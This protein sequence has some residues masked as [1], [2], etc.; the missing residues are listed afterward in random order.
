VSDEVVT[1]TEAERRAITGPGGTNNWEAALTAVEAI[2]TARLAPIEALA[3]G[4]Q[5]SWDE[6]QA[7]AKDGYSNPVQRF[8]R[9]NQAAAKI[10]AALAAQPP[11]PTQQTSE[12]R[13]E[14]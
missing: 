4:W 10:R 5:A 2:L 3:D 12:R 6:G 8:V 13:G 1:L 7:R 9:C 14:G 11:R